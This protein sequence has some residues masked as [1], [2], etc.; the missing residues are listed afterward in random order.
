MRLSPELI[1]GELE[2]LATLVEDDADDAEDA[3]LDMADALRRRLKGAET[4]HEPGDGAADVGARRPP[5]RGLG[6]GGRLCASGG[7]DDH[8]A[9]PD[10]GLD[11][12]GEPSGSQ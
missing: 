11:R 10:C 3:V 2:R 8:D 6:R 9:C 4:V 7:G 5:A 12:S 1:A